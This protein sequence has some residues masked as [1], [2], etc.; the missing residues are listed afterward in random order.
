MTATP[1]VELAENVGGSDNECLVKN[2]S[3]GRTPENVTAG[4]RLPRVSWRGQEPIVARF[5]SKVDRNGP[6]HPLLNTNCWQWTGCVVARYGQIGLGHPST[7]GSKRW[8]THR[9]SWELHNGPIPEGQTVRHKCDNPLCVRP[10]H[11]EIGTQKQNVH[12]SIL[13]GRRNA[14]GHQKLTVDDVRVIRLQLANGLTHAEI[15]SAFSIGRSTVTNIANN[16][17]WSSVA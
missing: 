3:V 2:E 15:A 12:D 8:K 6:R 16:H 14:F 5:W 17:T 7:P 11:L 1:Y 10:D 4:V 9:F 13:R